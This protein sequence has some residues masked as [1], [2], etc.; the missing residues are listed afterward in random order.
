[1]YSLNST[2][3]QSQVLSKEAVVRLSVFTE[4]KPYTWQEVF[5]SFV[6]DWKWL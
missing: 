3:S 5:F 4:K 1:M 6:S 2:A